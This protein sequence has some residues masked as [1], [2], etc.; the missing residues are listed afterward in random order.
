MEPVTG[1]EG[2]GLVESNWIIPSVN[3]NGSFTLNVTTNCT[4]S[5]NMFYNATVITTINM[6]M[7]G[8]IQFCTCTIRA[9]LQEK[10]PQGEIYEYSKFDIFDKTTVI[11]ILSCHNLEVKHMHTPMSES[12]H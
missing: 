2:L 11:A 10:G 1:S 12:A 6:T 3:V 8:N 4:L 5:A 9:V 7:A